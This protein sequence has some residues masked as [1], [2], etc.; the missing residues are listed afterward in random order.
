MT[1]ES[2]YQSP[3]CVLLKVCTEGFLCSSVDGF[4]STNE[5]NESFG[6][7]EDFIW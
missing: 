1:K 4:Y 2:N 5:S 6:K 7:L 3:V